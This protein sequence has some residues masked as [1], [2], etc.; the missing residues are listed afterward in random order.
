MPVRLMMKIEYDGTAFAG[1]QVQKSGRTVQGELERCLESLLGRPC[2]ITGSGRTDRGVHASGQVAHLDIFDDECDRV[3]SGLPELAPPDIAVRQIER[4]PDG[5][6]ARFSAVSREYAY[7]A[8]RG[9]RPLLS[10][11]AWECPWAE[12]D[13]DS[14]NLAASLSVGVGDWRGMAREGSGNSTWLVRVLGAGVSSDSEGWTF[15]IRADRF[16]RGMVRI[17]AGT[18]VEIGRGR[19][20]AGRIGEILSSGERRLA[21]PSLPACGLSLLSVEYDRGGEVGPQ[22]PPGTGPRAAAGARPAG[23]AGEGGCI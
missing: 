6:H 21:G 16:L 17:W 11:F 8:V 9:R 4:A 18:L 23:P 15:D 1:W 7:R 5:F 3:F 19:F 22:Q 12:L 10:R 14:M 13:T 2:R 20:G